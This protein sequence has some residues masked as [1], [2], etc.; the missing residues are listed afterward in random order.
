MS[1]S[2]E[3]AQ[4]PANFVVRNTAGKGSK[5]ATDGNPGFLPKDRLCKICEKHYNQI[6]PI[7]EEKVHQEKLKEGHTRLS[8]GENSRQK[9][10][11]KQK[12][13]FRNRSRATEKEKPRKGEAQAQTPCLEVPVSVEAR[14]S[15]PDYGMGNQAP[16]AKEALLAPRSGRLAENPRR[17]RKETRNPVRG[18]VTGSSERQRENKE[19]WD[20]VDRANSK[21]P[22]QAKNMYLSESEH[23]DRGRWK[24][25]SKKQRSTDEEDLSQPW[26]CEEAD[27]FTAGIRNFK[28]PKRTRMPTNVKT[29]DSTRDPEDHLKKFQTAKKIE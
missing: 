10:Q 25:R 23:N 5:Q 26:L 21:R 15:S 1:N 27:P 2:A 12:I 18:Y 7:M 8:Y 28:V 3:R 19:E 6:L 24:S 14:A 9:A 17:G 20:A 11:M 22:T 29:Y 16:P 4:T 13:S